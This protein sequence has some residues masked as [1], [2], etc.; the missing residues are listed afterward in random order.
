MFHP[1][2]RR[3]CLL[4]QAPIEDSLSSLTELLVSSR[5]V[6]DGCERTLSVAVIRGTIKAKGVAGIC[7]P[8]VG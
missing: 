2:D 7:W 8:L 3:F 5:V 1:M 4:A 6:P